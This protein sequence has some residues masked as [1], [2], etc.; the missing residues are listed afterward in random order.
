MGRLKIAIV[1]AVA[2]AGAALQCLAFEDVE[3]TVLRQAKTDISDVSRIGLGEIKDVSGQR[4]GQVV[5]SKIAAEIMD[6]GEGQFEVIDRNHMEALLAEQ[7]LQLAD[8]TETSASEFAKVADVDVI[9]TGTVSWT[10]EIITQTVPEEKLDIG[11][12]FAT[13]S[14]R[15]KTV[16]VEKKVMLASANVSVTMIDKKGY[17]LVAKSYSNRYNSQEDEEAK[18]KW[19]ESAAQTADKLPAEGVVID[20]LIEFCVDEFCK[21]IL[22]YE[23]TFKV[24]LG[25]GSKRLKQGVQ[26]MKAGL[27]EMAQDEFRAEIKSKPKSHEAHYNLGVTYELEDELDRALEEYRQALLLRSSNKTYQEAARNVQTELKRR[28]KP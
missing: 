27:I 24:K 19:F 3:V 20:R 13:E 7:S 18:T 22:P 2:V 28:K 11:G 23:M 5:S 15:T 8:L 26:F 14:L 9:V 1:V 4:Y 12:I 25:T 16:Y 21:E 10:S 6:R 17:A